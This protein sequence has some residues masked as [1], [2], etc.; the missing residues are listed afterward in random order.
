V[1]YKGYRLICQSIVPGI[2][3]NNDLSKLAEYGPVEDKKNYSNSEEFHELMLKVAEALNIKTSTIVDKGT[4]KN[5]ELASSS[6]VRGIRGTDQRCYLVEMQGLQPRDANYLGEE[7]QTA[8]VRPELVTAYQRTKTYEHVN[9]KISG[10]NE[11]V[12]KDRKEVPGEKDSEEQKK[13]LQ[14]RERDEAV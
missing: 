13:F 9:E 5:V 3:N 4:N 8:L 14:T 2:L 11:Q 12:V 7:Y 1:K 10:F 6:D